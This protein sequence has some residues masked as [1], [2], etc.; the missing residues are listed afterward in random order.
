MSYSGGVG[1]WYGALSRE[2]SPRVEHKAEALTE[3]LLL[4][5][6]LRTEGTLVRQRL[7]GENCA[8]APEGRSAQ[9]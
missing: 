9:R 1:I 4:Q 2:V 7:W 8:A 3:A 6:E 5:T